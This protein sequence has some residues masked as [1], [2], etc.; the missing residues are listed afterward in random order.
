MTIVFGKAVSVRILYQNYVLKVIVK[1][2]PLSQQLES[3]SQSPKKRLKC[4]ECSAFSECLRLFSNY[5]IIRL[6]CL[7]V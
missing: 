5:P 2:M 4:K 3:E 7:K 6:I 1:M